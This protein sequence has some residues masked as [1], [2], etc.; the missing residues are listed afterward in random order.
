[1]LRKKTAWFSCT[2]GEHTL[3]LTPIKEKGFSESEDKTFITT[4]RVMESEGVQLPQEFY[5]VLSYCFTKTE[6]YGY[7]AVFGPGVGTAI[8]QSNDESWRFEGL[9]PLHIN[10]GDLDYST[11]DEVFI[12]VKWKYKTV[13]HTNP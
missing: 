9:Y 7:A 1:M 2:F 11:S 10:F 6:E 5:N 3:P 8:I 13:T 4:F 12:E